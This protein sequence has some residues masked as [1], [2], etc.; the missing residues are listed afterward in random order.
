MKLS[1]ERSDAA[2]SLSRR[3]HKS[4]YIHSIQIKRKRKGNARSCSTSLYAHF[5]V[6]ITQ[7][8]TW[9]RIQSHTR[10]NSIVRN[11]IIRD[12]L[13]ICT[14]LSLPLSYKLIL[15]N[16]HANTSQREIRTFSFSIYWLY[17]YISRSNEQF[18]LSS[19]LLIEYL[20][21]KYISWYSRWYC[22]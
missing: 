17:M 16:R 9:E 11:D 8:H 21:F 5:P 6:Y 13:S 22:L 20:Q 10:K 4:I 7:T 1:M 18:Y 15:L 19:V 12:E 2:M 14:A 3:T